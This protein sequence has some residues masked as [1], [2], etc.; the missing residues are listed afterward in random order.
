MLD[1]I[2]NVKPGDIIKTK[3]GTALL[4][5]ETRAKWFYL[6]KNRVNS[7]NKKDFWRMVDTGQIKIFY[8]DKKYRRK[9]KK[10]RTLDIRNVPSSDLSKSLDF[11]LDF[12]DPPCY[13]VLDSPAWGGVNDM[14]YFLIKELEGRDFSFKIEKKTQGFMCLKIE[15]NID[16]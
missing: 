16:L 12:V 1:N 4:V 13:V 8:T 6:F 5:K 15:K 14:S 10:N 2:Y 11:F 7:L 9:Q 3:I